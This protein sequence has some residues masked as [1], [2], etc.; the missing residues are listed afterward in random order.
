MICKLKSVPSAPRRMCFQTRGQHSGKYGTILEI[1]RAHRPR[2]KG[3]KRG[4]LVRHCGPPCL[5]RKAIDVLADGV[6]RALALAAP[7]VTPRI[8]V[9]LATAVAN[10]QTALEDY[11]TGVPTVPS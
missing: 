5:P 8:K 1:V 4:T 11:C 3:L 10:R 9:M 7:G 2:P 6:A